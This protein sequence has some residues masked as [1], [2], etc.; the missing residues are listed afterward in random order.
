MTG[1]ARPKV[2]LLDPPEPATVLQV[3]DRTLVATIIAGDRDAYRLLVERESTTVFRC[4][5]RVLGHIEDAQ[6]VAQESF[7]AAYRSLETWRGDGSLRAW[8]AQI[9][10]RQALRAIGRRVRPASLDDSPH[11]AD[12]ASGYDPTPDSDPVAALS[13]ADRAAQVRDAVTKLPEPY[14]ETI[15]LRYFAELSIEEIARTLDRPV[16][17]VKVHVHRGLE[18]LRAALAEESAA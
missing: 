2:G 12:V 17:T 13:L 10:T 16:G 14:R 6:D 5:Y 1:R 4:C 18:R 9:A 8:L 7:V 3:D 15:A 11:G